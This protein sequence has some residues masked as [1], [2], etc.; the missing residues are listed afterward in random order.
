MFHDN[1]IENV[2]PRLRISIKIHVYVN[3]YQPLCSLENTNRCFRQSFFLN[4]HATNVLSIIL[5]LAST[6]AP[7]RRCPPGRPNDPCDLARSDIAPVFGPW[8]IPTWGRGSRYI[9]RGHFLLTLSLPPPPQPPLLPT[10][11]ALFLFTHAPF[12]LEKQRSSAYFAP[13][14]LT[15]VSVTP[16]GWR[17]VLFSNTIKMHILRWIYLFAAFIC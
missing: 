17:T 9:Y 7:A 8:N 3:V 5:A 16:I 6:H 4:L 15:D 11:A 12:L 1:V 2:E 14:Q 13:R 10:L